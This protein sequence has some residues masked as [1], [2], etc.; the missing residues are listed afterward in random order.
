MK[1]IKI[2]K[3]DWNTKDTESLPMTCA[4]KTQDDF[5]MNDFIHRLE[6][7]YKSMINSVTYYSIVIPSTVEELLHTAGN[8][9]KKKSIYSLSGKLSSYGQ[10]CMK[11]L[12]TLMTDIKTAEK[13]NVSEF[14]MPISYNTVMLGWENITGQ[15][16]GNQSVKELM[17]PVKS[18]TGFPMTIKTTLA[19]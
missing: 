16:W 7:K 6:S 1:A 9:R 15:K 18:K 11:N 3:I 19:K 12:E 13:N 2:Q 10:R 14:D 17:K 4:F 8:E 5:S